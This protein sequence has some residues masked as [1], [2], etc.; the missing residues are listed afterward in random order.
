MPLVIPHLYDL[1]N[2]AV[3][4]EFRPLL[5]ELCA[6]NLIALLQPDEVIGTENWT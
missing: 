2:N 3:K 4:P 1:L 6:E 5:E